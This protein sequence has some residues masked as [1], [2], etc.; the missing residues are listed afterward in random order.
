MKKRLVVATAI[1]IL[2]AATAAPG[3]DSEMTVKADSL[4]I[5]ENSG[6]ITFEGNVEVRMPAGALTC[7][8]L[9]LE[10]APGDPSTIR[11]GIATG[12]VM[13]TRN[14]DRLRADSAVIDMVERKATFSGSPVLVRGDSRLAAGEIDYDMESGVADFKGP[15]EA[16]FVTVPV[17][18]P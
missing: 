15:I 5:E 16:S 17:G 6:L 3:A 4:T 18:T 10:T 1:A 7:R 13:L 9:S 12:D 8:A 14:G 2:L 11:K